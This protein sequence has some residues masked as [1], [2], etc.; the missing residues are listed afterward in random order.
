[1]GI[2]G[3]EVSKQAAD[4]ILMDDNFASIVT[5]VEEGR[6]IFDNLKKAIVYTLTSK[7]PETLP[8]LVFIL[9][10]LP[11]A[12]GTAMIL[13]IDFSTDLVCKT[14]FDFLVF[15]IIHFEFHLTSD[16]SHLIGA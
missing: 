10:D 7:G 8:F 12:L 5:G 16:T 14:N 15:K 4:M 6:V 9:M 13:L 11:L 3:S 1:M 2:S